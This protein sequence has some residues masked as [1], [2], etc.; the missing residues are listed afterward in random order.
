MAPEGSRHGFK[1]SLQRLILNPP[2]ALGARLAL[3]A[4]FSAIGI[5][6]RML[7]AGVI[8]QEAPFVTVF[9]ALLAACVFAGIAGGLACLF[10]S[11]G[12]AGWIFVQANHGVDPSTGGPVALGLFLASGGAIVGI[13]AL[14]RNTLAE[15]S[16][17]RK[18]QELLLAELQHRVKNTLTVV[19]GLA[20]QTLRW[21]PDPTAFGPAFTARL[22]ALGDAH[23]L[24]SDVA[25]TRV[26]LRTLVQRATGPFRT[27]PERIRVAGE[28]LHLP[29]QQ[30][31]N[32]ALCF[33][34]LATNAIKYG[35][36]SRPEGWVEIGWHAEGQAAVR[37][38]TVQWVEH[39]GPPVEAP[40]RDGFGSHLLRRAFSG[41]AAL[42]ANLEF[43]PQGVRWTAVLEL[44]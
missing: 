4:V 14:L 18:D 20:S 35:A 30:A 22:A 13:V 2:E 21:S 10:L 7:L 5:G 8:N 9:P 33:N 16:A 23:S 32:L 42:G 28:D 11:A 6:G 31:I 34:E 24:V 17:A 25:W 26:S 38:L 1:R 37:R 19:Q 43:Q 29:A 12:A 41:G 3:G 15:V 36:L 39:D 27:S 44:P 40:N